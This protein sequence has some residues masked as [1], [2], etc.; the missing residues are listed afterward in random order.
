MTATTDRFAGKRVII[1]GAASGFGEAMARSFGAEGAS[2]LVAD[3]DAVRAEQVAA[4]LPTALPFEIDVTNQDQTRAMAE[5]AVEAWAG[6]GVVCANAGLPHRAT[7]LIDLPTDE[8]DRMFAVNVRS[9][10]LAAKHCVPHMSEGG[11]IIATA[12]IGGIRPRPGLT[13]YNA[14]KRAVIT[15][16][17]G[18]ATELAPAIRVNA[19]LPVSA[20]TGFDKNALGSDMPENLER[21]VIRGIPMGR[22]ATPQDVANAALFLASDQASFLTGVSLDIDGG[23]SIH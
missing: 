23:R 10:Y 15:L 21:A 18:L 11:S 2:V 8:F 20:A 6:I 4:D 19:V 3:I 17:R 9:V 13:A 22:R 1:T 16:V 5:A 14:S 7:N 12:S